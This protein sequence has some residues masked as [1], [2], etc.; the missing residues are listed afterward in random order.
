MMQQP[1]PV[2]PL[3]II[4]YPDVGDALISISPDRT[5]VILT[6]DNNAAAEDAAENND[7]TVNVNGSIDAITAT[8]VV[9][10]TVVLTLAT[11]IPDGASVNVNSI[12]TDV[13][14]NRIVIKLIVI[15]HNFYNY[16]EGE[17]SIC[18]SDRF[19]ETEAENECR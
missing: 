9:G 4:E 11:P 8:N 16:S 1:C 15:G 2:P 7:F 12:N 5:Q 18:C 3:S 13:G 17:T 6:Y 19:F 14:E 10:S